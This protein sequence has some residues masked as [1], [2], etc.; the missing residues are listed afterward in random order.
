MF[1][2]EAQQLFL[3]INRLHNE[4]ADGWDQTEWLGVQKSLLE[5]WDTPGL[6]DYEL[7]YEQAMKEW[8]AVNS[9]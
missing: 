8:N 3:R 2:Q 5:E 1:N 7:T 4:G 9:K 6:P